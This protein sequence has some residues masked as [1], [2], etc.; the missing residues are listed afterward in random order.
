MC[1]EQTT[2]HPSQNQPY[3]GRLLSLQFPHLIALLSDLLMNGSSVPPRWRW[4][5]KVLVAGLWGSCARL[6]V[7]ACDTLVFS[8]QSQQCFDGLV[9][10]SLSPWLHTEAD[11]GYE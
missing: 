10:L 8:F 3:L 5:S 11:E 2:P 9:N 7:L 1:N 4:C 6:P